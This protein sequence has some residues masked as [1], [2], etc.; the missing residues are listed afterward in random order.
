MKNQTTP[1]VDGYMDELN[2]CLRD[3][4]RGRREEIIGEIR[5]HIDAALDD[6]GQQS[7]AVIATILDQLGSPEEIAAAARIDAPPQQSRITTRDTITILLLLIG[8]FVLPLIGWIIGVVMLWTSNAWRTRDKILATLLV[9]GGLLSGV[10]A[11]GA[12][13]VY[14]MSGIETTCRPQDPNFG[15]GADHCVTTGGPG[16]GTWTLLTIVVILTIVGP[17]FTTFWLTRQARRLV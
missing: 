5:A 3:L 4:P 13:P 1:A 16:A 7:P 2:L 11:V 14:S 15:T 12:I 17:L 6:A 9:P 10:F 8:G